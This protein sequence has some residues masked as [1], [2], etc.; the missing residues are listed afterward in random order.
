MI[1]AKKS[2]LEISRILEASLPGIA[3]KI[4]RGS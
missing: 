4:I 1:V 2:A 3:I